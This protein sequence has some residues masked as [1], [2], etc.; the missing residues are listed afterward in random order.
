MFNSANREI[1]L[2]GRFDAAFCAYGYSN[3][4]KHSLAFKG[5]RQDPITGFYLLGNGYR[6]YYPTLRRFNSPDNE[7]PFARGWLNAYAFC[8]CDPINRNDPTGH[9]FEF[10]TYAI[11]K[12]SVSKTYSGKIVAEFHEIIAFTGPSRADGKLPTLYISAHGKPGVISADRIHTFSATDTFEELRRQG[13]DMHRRQTHVLAC[14]SAIP[15]S[16]TGKSFIE[17][18][19]DHTGAQTSGYG[20][21]VPVVERRQG[22]V[23]IAEK[24]RVLP[25]SYGFTATKTRAG[26]IRNPHKNATDR[27]SAQ[28][29]RIITV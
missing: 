14:D 7:S 4:K 12:L 13:V 16:H 28:P 25:L 2:E 23:F 11:N 21:S 24:Q 1:G 29:G 9:F 8:L 19:S 26:N 18:F 10:I 15:N 22:N 17:E 6:A 20:G 3:G 5:E 27:Q